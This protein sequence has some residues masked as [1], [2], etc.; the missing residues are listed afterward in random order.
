[1]VEPGGGVAPHADDPVPVSPVP[2]S[3]RVARLRN[4]LHVTANRVARFGFDEHP[5]L[6]RVR[7]PATT[8][9]GGMLA[10]HLLLVRLDL[11][12]DRLVGLLGLLDVDDWSRVGRIGNR[13]VT[14]GA[15]VD[16]VVQRG[17]D[18]LLGLLHAGSRTCQVVAPS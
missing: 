2:A 14:L 7:T 10:P 15:I 4:E 11:T 6:D 18:D 1:L 16:E 9:V 3:R 17:F 13:Q 12:V 5:I 8:A